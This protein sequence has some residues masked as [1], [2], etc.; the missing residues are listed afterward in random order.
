MRLTTHPI[1]WNSWAMRTILPTTDHWPSGMNTGSLN[2]SRQRE[3]MHSQEKR[4]PLT[5]MSISPNEDARTSL[6]T[7]E[8]VET[9][10]RRPWLERRRG[11]PVLSAYNKSERGREK[12]REM[13]AQV[14]QC[15]ECGE[16]VRSYIGLFNHRRWRHRVHFNHKVVV[17][18]P[19][20]Q[21][22]DVYCLNVPDLG[23]FALAAGVFV[24]NCGMMAAKTTLTAS[25]LP[26]SLRAV[27]TAIERAVP[28]GRSPGK[29]DRGA[30]GASPPAAVDA[31]WATLANGFAR[32]VERV[33]ALARTNNRMHL[34]TLGAG[35]H[36]VEVCLDESGRV[37]VNAAFSGSR[38]IGNAHRLALHRA[39]EGGHAELDDQSPGPATSLISTEGTEHFDD[40][41]EAVGWAQDFARAN[42]EVMMQS[43]DRARV[44]ASSPSRSTRRR[45][46]ELPPQLRRSASSTSAR[47]SW[48]RARAR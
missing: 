4:P 12:S 13:A 18:R 44:R 1:T 40:Y 7:C 30:W 46:G 45:G 11:A 9:T 27:R 29:R 25:D 28:H 21:R 15:P 47:T 3:N 6:R 14:H 42:R 2:P 31:A 17:V 39:S 34:G 33:S 32:L 41:V 16:Q 22:A 23:N 26:D 24:H 19:L 5:D 38:G 36:F 48:S 43:R 37:W 8:I 10:S 20:D 35:N